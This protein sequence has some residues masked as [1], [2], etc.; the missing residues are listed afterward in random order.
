MTLVVAGAV[1]YDVQNRT[2]VTYVMTTV[3]GDVY[4]GRTSGYGDPQ[5][6]VDRR[7]MGHR[8][9]ALGY[10]NPIV[11]RFAQGIQ[12]R[13]AIRGCEQQLIDHFGGIGSP[14]LGNSIRGVSK[15]NVFGKTYHDLS[16]FYFGQLHEFT[17]IYNYQ[18]IK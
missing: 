4:V 1:T 13:Y 16:N 2:F 10:Q 18:L 3:D 17:G 6:I 9:K 8:M 14:G 7:Y 5:S 11:D 15:T 12:G